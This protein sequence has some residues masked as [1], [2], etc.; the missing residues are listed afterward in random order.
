M[1][2]ELCQ[3]PRRRESAATG[4]RL[5]GGRLRP[6]PR[7]HQEP[8]SGDVQSRPTWPTGG[9]RRRTCSAARRYAHGSIRAARSPRGVDDILA[10]QL[11]D[12]VAETDCR[13]RAG[14]VILLGISL[15]AVRRRLVEK[16]NC[17]DVAGLGCRVAAQDCHLAGDAAHVLRNHLAEGVALNGQLLPGSTL[18]LSLTRCSTSPPWV[19]RIGKALLPMKTPSPFPSA[20]W[21]A[22]TP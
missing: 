14:T 16:D 17:K 11:A 21:P 18:S 15:T 20:P 13:S 10:Q 2:Y 12:L 8:S 5:Y 3:R 9:L 4:H 19:A 1:G 22:I 6:S 7:R